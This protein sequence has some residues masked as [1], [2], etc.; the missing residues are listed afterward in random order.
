MAATADQPPTPAAETAM[1]A[2]ADAGWQVRH[3]GV[4][5]PSFWQTTEI[6]EAPALITATTKALSSPPA[7][8]TQRAAEQQVA[9]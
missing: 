3:H 6:E 2:W 1:K 8:A 7:L 5:G 9:A 4:A